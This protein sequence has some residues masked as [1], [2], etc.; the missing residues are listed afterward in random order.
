MLTWTIT[1]IHGWDWL[2]ILM[3]FILDLSAWA[4]S[5][6]NRKN[7]PGYTGP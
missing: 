6:S 1:G 3:G 2:W 4:Q 5:A 7:V